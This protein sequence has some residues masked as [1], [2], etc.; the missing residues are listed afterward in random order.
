MCVCVHVL[1]G[2]S[3][4]YTPPNNPAGYARKYKAFVYLS[5]HCKIRHCNKYILFPVGY[6]PEP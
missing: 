4:Q 5:M 6:C 3:S 1:L 2:S